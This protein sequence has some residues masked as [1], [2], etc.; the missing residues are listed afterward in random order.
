MTC[1]IHVMVISM[2]DHTVFS[3]IVYNGYCYQGEEPN[4]QIAFVPII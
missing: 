1:I 3:A 4:K 2:L